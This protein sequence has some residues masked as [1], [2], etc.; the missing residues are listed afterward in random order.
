M[1]GAKEK[2]EKRQEKGQK[3][4]RITN[5]TEP[6]RPVLVLTQRILATPVTAAAAP[7]L[8]PAKTP[9]LSA[10]RRQSILPRPKR[11]N[12]REMK[13]DAKGTSAGTLQ[14][15]RLKPRTKSP[16]HPR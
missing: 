3:E 6:E 1:K 8:K 14:A 4:G 2:E 7:P 11:R 15:K 13:K 5:P 16:R 12:H 10:G 9:S